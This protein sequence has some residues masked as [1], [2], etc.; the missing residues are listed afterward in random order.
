M[1]VN[2]NSSFCYTGCE[3]GHRHDPCV[4]RQ[5]RGRRRR[6]STSPRT[7]RRRSGS[8]A[9]EVDDVALEPADATNP[10]N[11]NHTLTATVTDGGTP[12]EG[13]QVVFVMKG[14]S[15]TFNGYPF[16]FVL[17]TD[18]T[19]SAGHAQA[20]WSSAQPGTDNVEA[21]CR[22]RPRRPARTAASRRHRHQA[23]GADHVR[24]LGHDDAR[25][26]RRGRWSAPDLLQHA[27]RDSD[28]NFP[29]Q[30]PVVFTV[31]GDNPQAADPS[32][33]TSTATRASATRVQRGHG[34]DP[35]V[36]RQRPGRDQ[37]FDEPE[38]TSTQ[39]WLSDR[40][41]RRRRARARRLPPTRSTPT[42]P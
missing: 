13:V 24:E 12:V 3:R 41:G 6:T 11:T 28:N 39:D 29:A 15:A 27:A 9:A 19:D 37:D 35:C 36:R 21:L 42:T 14:G 8:R 18:E 30:R 4:R 22:H 17:A 32:R 2:G 38:D 26:R 10:I 23:L 20:T 40:R 7:P 34:H 25:G 5:R 33:W 1:D 31:T 16:D